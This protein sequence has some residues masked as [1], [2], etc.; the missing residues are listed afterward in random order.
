ME[1]PDKIYLHPDIGDKEF[2]RPW[3]R[4]AANSESVAYI[5]KDTILTWA[6]EHQERLEAIFDAMPSSVVAGKLQ[7]YKEVIEKIKSL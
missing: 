4:N 1:A 6:E 5:H 2:I 3:L 7:A